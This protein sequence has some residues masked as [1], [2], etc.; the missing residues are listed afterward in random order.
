MISKLRHFVLQSYFLA[1]VICLSLIIFLPNIFDKYEIR[2]VDS[3]SLFVDSNTQ[4][5]NYDIDHNGYSE[6]IYSF[7]FYEKHAIQIFTHDGGM[8]DQW[9]MNGSIAG[10][11]ERL[12]SGDY[13]KDGFDEIYTFYQ[14]SDTILLYCFEPLD[15][16]SPLSFTKEILCSLN[17]KYAEPDHAIVNIN[18]QDINGD[19][20][21]EIIFVIISGQARFPRNIFVY[22]IFNDT[23]I[24]SPEFGIT[25]NSNLNFI[26]F[27]DDGKKE[28]FGRT[29]AV[30]QVHDSLGFK[31]G[32]Y[33]A[34]LMV[35]DYNLNL[36]FEPIKFPGFLSWLDVQAITIDGEKLLICYYNHL[37]RSD[38]YPKLFLVNNKGET[39]KEHIFP[40]SSKIK[41]FL[42]VNDFNGES[43]F[44]IIDENGHIA[45]YSIDFQLINKYDLNSTVFS[46]PL[47]IDLNNDGRI[48]WVFNSKDRCLLITDQEF[49]NPIMLKHHFPLSSNGGSPLIL[50]GNNRPTLFFY[51]NNNEFLSIQYGK[52]PL[53]PLRLLIYLGIYFIIWSFILIIRKLQL[54]QI[55]KQESIRKQIV[56]LQLKSFRNQMDPHFTFNVFTAMAHKIMK[57][58]PKSYEAF[59]KF[60]NLMRTTLES[61]DQITRTIDE[62]LSSL[63]D[64]LYFEM[65]RFPDKLEYKIDIQKSVNRNMKIPKMILQTYVENSIKHGIMHKDGN[66]LVKINIAKKN[67]ALDIDIS[68]N[69]IGREKAKLVSTESTGYGL[70]IMD[71][72]FRLFNEYNE[73]KI[74]YEIIDLFDKKNNATGTKVK[75]SIPLNFSYKLQ[76]YE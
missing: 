6:Q 7:D 2:I 12:I 34:W 55:K 61:S 32:D 4:V 33:N 22:D 11:G 17:R 28:I 10:G 41:R 38:N 63:E 58:N 67:Q 1:L 48:E 46:D 31:Y 21:E 8:I 53:A 45:I 75:I 20:R 73:S 15:T 18:F 51:S 3:G 16:I 50:N 14:R 27:D 40:K 13:D 39:V 23:L 70:R 30:G 5:Y 59:M 57:E 56:D 9:N 72:Y 36:L 42:Y 76:K 19:D 24:K 69:G 54:I 25:L 65:I 43:R 60:S 37:G 49:K 74:K 62:E 47:Q 66:G 68:D 52:N 71:N 44:N 26:D 35:Y 64:Y 29:G